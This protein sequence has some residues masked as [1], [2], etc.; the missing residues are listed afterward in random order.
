MEEDFYNIFSNK[1]KEKLD[2]EYVDSL[3]ELME[4]NELKK[5]SFLKLVEKFMSKDWLYER[6]V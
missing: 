2:E 1:L 5:E 4:N 3:I 6:I